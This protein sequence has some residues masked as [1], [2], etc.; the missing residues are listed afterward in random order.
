MSNKKLE[1][2]NF[3][4][5]KKMSLMPIKENTKLPIKQGWQNL[6]ISADEIKSSFNKSSSQNVGMITGKPSNVIVLD[7]D[8]KNGALGEKTYKLLFKLFGEKLNTLKSNTPSGGF[9]LFFRP[10]SQVSLKNSVN[11]LD[12]LDIRSD[13]GFVVVP[14]SC[15][16]GSYYVFEN[17]NAPILPLPEGLAIILQ[18]VSRNKDIIPPLDI[19]KGERN[20][21]IFEYSRK[22]HKVMPLDKARVLVL[23][24]AQLCRP[25]FSEDEAIKCLESAKNYIP[26]STDTSEIINDLNKAYSVVLDGGK[27]YVMKEQGNPEL[28]RKDTIFLLPA[29]FHNLLANRRIVDS[30]G[31]SKAISRIWFNDPDRRQYEG[32]CFSPNNKYEGY[33]NLWQGFAVTPKEGKWSTF[34]RHIR[35]NICSGDEKLYKYIIAWMADAVQKPDV[36]P[37]TSI[38]LRGS[39]GTGK[40]LFATIFGSLFGRHFIH[41]TSNKHLTGNFNSHMRDVSLIFA[42]EAIW[43]GDKQA[44]GV[45]KAL[46]TENMIPIESKGK[47]VIFARSYIRLIVASNNSWVVPAGLEE[48]RFLIIDVS[49]RK[50]QNTRFFKRLVNEMDNGGKEAMLFDLMNYDYSDVN[51]KKIPRTEALE[52]MKLN[53][54]T[55]IQRFMYDK[56]MAGS[57]EDHSD[58]WPER[59]SVGQFFELYCNH[60]GRTGSKNR[61]GITQFG[62]EIKKLLPPFEII[63]V[64]MALN[65]HDKKQV[66][67][68][69]LPNLEECRKYFDKITR[70]KHDWGKGSGANIHLNPDD[71]I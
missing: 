10:V 37:G 50:M 15:I 45:L 69:Q 68:Y 46:V 48:R 55:P 6:N 26:N 3:L 5:N 4:I 62:M 25:S 31:K 1:A 66:R 16:D 67:C 29:D 30:E 42:D 52:E 38:V 36:K 70:S 44:E 51:L 59:I 61:G 34:R 7:F 65:N 33:Y 47:D 14:P 11:I 57:L 27:C 12:G 41:V 39:Q 28:N 64:S 19:K 18:Y 71:I 21:A 40:S 53:S 2:I 22:L 8:V 54:M 56:L 24:A 23:L 60:A 13:G 58:K 17:K 63:K 20:H 9:H 32:V 49:S 43:G 35:N